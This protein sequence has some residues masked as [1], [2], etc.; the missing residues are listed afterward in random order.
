MMALILWA[1]LPTGG[2]A[3]LTSAFVIAFPS[4]PLLRALSR[5]VGNADI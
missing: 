1:V 3:P 2:A 5:F 4:H